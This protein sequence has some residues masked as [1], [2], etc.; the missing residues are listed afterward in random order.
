[1]SLKKKISRIFVPTSSSEIEIKEKLSSLLISYFEISNFK[2]ISKDNL[3]AIRKLF[4]E[5]D[6]LSLFVKVGNQDTILF[7]KF[8][9]IGESLSKLKEEQSEF[10]EEED[11]VK[12]QLE[13]NKD[14]TK[15]ISV[16][17]FEEFNLFWSTLSEN[18]ILELINNYKGDDNILKFEIIEQEFQEFYSN[19]IIFSNSP[20]GFKSVNKVI[21]LA[22]NCHFHNYSNLS[23]TPD[24]FELKKRPTKSCLISESLDKLSLVFCITSLFDITSIDDDSNLYYKL[25]GYKSFE[26]NIP[27]KKMLLNSKDTYYRIF[28]WV[29]SDDSHISD[30]I[31]LTRNILSLS[32]VNRSIEIEESVYHSIQSGYQTYLKD[33]INKYI[34]I[35]E[36]IT[37]E[38]SWISQ[39][40]GEIIKEYIGAYE[41]SLFVFLSF[42][43]S[44]FLFK[45]LKGGNV[46]N[47]FTIDATIFSFAFLLLSGLFLYYSYKKIVQ[48]IS[49]L[50]RKYSNLKKRY[51]DLL[52]EDDINKILSN[53]EEFNFELE[54]IKARRNKNTTL[55]I[56]TILILFVTV[57]GLSYFKK[58]NMK[59]IENNKVNVLRI[60]SLH[61]N[62][63]KKIKKDSII[64]NA[65]LPQTQTKTNIK[66]QFLK[67]SSKSIDTTFKSLEN[68]I[69]VANDSTKINTSN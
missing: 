59:D 38:L 46:D 43:I 55:W 10:D 67:D 27:I 9:D 25:N 44:V 8:C 20:L 19:N 58:T 16:Y 3:Y 63:E 21:E 53:D 30:K 24:F 48:E 36:K 62:Y 15:S 23:F 50:K 12:I 1:M 7:D 47:I 42:F 28:E 29:Y 65:I 41:K 35:R 57:T 22:D 56:I 32:L 33:N 68:N 17:D 5:Q 40:F 18:E 37:D 66:V 51:L 2:D 61:I 4:K 31:G 26:D 64:Q 45:F 13:V 14:T 52:N 39:K 11:I 54:Y 69:K 6:L 60:E 34:E 49:R